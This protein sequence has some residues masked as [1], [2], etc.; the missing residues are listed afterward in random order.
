MR[1]ETRIL[2]VDD[3]Q[4]ILT[5][6][7]LCLKPYVNDVLTLINPTE[8]MGVL[9]CNP[10]DL[11]LLDMNF[12][13]DASSGEEGI[14][15]LK[16]I[17]AAYPQLP[18]IMMT[19]Y[20]GVTLAV[21]AMHLGAKD[22]IAKPW[23][24]QQL[25]D[26]VVHVSK[27]TRKTCP[28][29]RGLKSL[30]APSLIG[31][32]EPM[33]AVQR[34][35]EKV[36]GSNANV[37]ILGESGTGKEV[38]AK[39]IHALSQR[40]QQAFVAVDM[41]TLPENLFES[42]V[43]GYRKG[44]FTGAMRD[45]DGRIVHAHQGTLFLDELGNLPL[46]QQSKLLTV[47]Q[48]REVIAV[49]A[50]EAKA[51]DIRLICATNENLQQQVVDGK[52]R[53]DLFY[54]INTVEIH[55]PPLRE[56]GDDID[57]LLD[58]YCKQ[59]A[60]HYGRDELSITPSDRKWLRAYEWPGNVREL[61]HSVERAVVLADS[62]VLDF[63]QL[64]QGNSTTMQECLTRNNGPDEGRF[65]LDYVERKTIQQA[66]QFYRGNIS[67]AAKALGLTRGAMYRRMEK[68]SL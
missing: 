50:I 63:S 19:A 22:F 62:D 35:M 16:Q 56:R 21:R 46:V 49:G 10:I 47:L 60:A 40:R 14:F 11:V 33:R 53:Q 68:Y 2:I 5:A 7:R 26:A 54:R 32:S 39:S 36:A 27:Q 52:F 23:S 61:A 38:V 6:C 66:L 17:N 20:A 43:F 58:Y 44:A 64:A 59:Y 57:L 24:N 37:L 67:Q 4:D 41:G 48:N 51:V 34:L 8:L 3:N 65:L 9:K 15:Y 45:S 30:E 55:L 29:D 28:L 31:Q 42:E 25:I 18:V 13:R 12:T 1:K